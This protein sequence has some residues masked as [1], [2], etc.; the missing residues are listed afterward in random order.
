MRPILASNRSTGFL[1][2]LSANIMAEPNVSLRNCRATSR[3]LLRPNETQRFFIPSSEMTGVECAGRALRVLVVEDDYDAAS[4]LLALLSDEGH[5]AKGVYKASDVWH[6]VPRFD[7]D[8]VLIDIGLPDRSGYEVAQKIRR[9]FG[10]D[11]PYLIA[12]TAWTKG[13]DKILAKLAGFNEHVGKPYDPNKLLRLL[14]N[15]KS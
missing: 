15:L 10:D 11:R 7:P 13:S 6:T 4:T 8:V 14:A 1:Y 5:E 9:R 12:V 2:P 3:V